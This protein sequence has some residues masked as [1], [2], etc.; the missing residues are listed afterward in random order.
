MKKVRGWARTSG[1]AAKPG[2]G[3]E[4]SL[5]IPSDFL[6]ERDSALVV[7]SDSGAD[8]SAPL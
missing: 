2:L 1:N 6:P 5:G 7:R 3:G 8:A 4:A